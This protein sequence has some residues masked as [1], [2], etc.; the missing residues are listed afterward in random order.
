MEGDFVGVYQDVL[1]DITETS[2]DNGFLDD[3]IDIKNAETELKVKANRPFMFM[4]KMDHELL[5]LGRI[6]VHTKIKTQPTI[7]CIKIHKQ[8]EANQS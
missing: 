5:G 7:L 1:I 2:S 6:T 3:D 4:I 8:L